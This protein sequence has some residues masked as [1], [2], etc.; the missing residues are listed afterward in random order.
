M[1]H[2]LAHS[3]ISFNQL[4]IFFASLLGE[5]LALTGARLNAK[6]MI[7][8]GLATHFVLSEVRL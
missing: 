4:I 2:N 8:A 6:E 1:M 7:A 3:N 5:Y